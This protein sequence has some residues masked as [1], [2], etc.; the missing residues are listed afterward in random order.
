M[1]VDRIEQFQSTY[2]KCTHAGALF[3]IIPISCNIFVSNSI[4]KSERIKYLI[5][6]QSC[7]S[8]LFTACLYQGILVSVTTIIIIHQSTRKQQKDIGINIKNYNALCIYI[9]NKIK[10]LFREE[11]QYLSSDFNYLLKLPQ[12]ITHTNET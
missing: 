11:M 1:M 8:F 6:K 10:S 12:K 2:L 5:E 3:T 9:L 7:I 4:G